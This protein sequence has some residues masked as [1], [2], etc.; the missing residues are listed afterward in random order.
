VVRRQIDNPRGALMSHRQMI[1][2]TTTGGNVNCNSF[3][4]N[5]RLDTPEAR[6]FLGRYLQLP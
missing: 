2:S 6:Q 4:Y 1:V 5:Y 3:N